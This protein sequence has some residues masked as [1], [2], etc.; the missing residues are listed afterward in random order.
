MSFKRTVKTL[1]NHTFRRKQIDLRIKSMSI[2]AEAQTAALHMEHP[3]F[4]EFITSCVELLQERGGPNSL[5]ISFFSVIDMKD[6][7]VE[8]RPVTGLPSNVI[9]ARLRYALE[10]IVSGHDEPIRAAR[11]A[12]DYCGY[13]DPSGEEI[14]PN[15]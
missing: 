12:L 15:G 11:T 8:I 13:T 4:V 6:Y 10:Q 9:I 5:T 3:V 7:L 14:D 1:F 2:D